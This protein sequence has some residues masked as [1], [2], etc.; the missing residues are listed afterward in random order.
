MQVRK[1]EG[2]ERQ[3]R[4]T[5]RNEERTIAKIILGPITHD[6]QKLFNKKMSRTAH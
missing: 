4:G 6:E 3:K 1:E 2:K 5:S